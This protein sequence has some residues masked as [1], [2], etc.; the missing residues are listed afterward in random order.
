M[1]Q[2]RDLPPG[3]VLSLKPYR[4]R[5]ETSEH[6][7]CAFCFAKFMDPRFSEE[8]RRFVAERAD[9]LTEGY[10]TTDERGWV[11]PRCFDDFADELG[12]RQADR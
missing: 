5:S 7:H 2:E 3:T 8:H 12:W 1:G 11:C 4:A 10:A 9:V 6:E